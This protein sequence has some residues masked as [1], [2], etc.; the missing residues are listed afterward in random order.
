MFGLSVGTH[1]PHTIID[2]TAKK[3]RNEVELFSR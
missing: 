3:G 1:T 2:L